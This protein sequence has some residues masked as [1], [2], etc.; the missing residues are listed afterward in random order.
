MKVI[1]AI[2]YARSAQDQL[3]YLMKKLEQL[4]PQDEYKLDGSPFA[5][6]FILTMKLYQD[7][8]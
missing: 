1:N 4:D 5:D 2:R 6:I 3:D 8:Y 7:D